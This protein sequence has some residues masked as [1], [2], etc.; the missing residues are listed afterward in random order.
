[1]KVQRPFAPCVEYRRR[2]MALDFGWG[3]FDEPNLCKNGFRF[4]KAVSYTVYLLG[5]N[6][7][8]H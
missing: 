6:K 3:W 7:H 8:P 1:V 5:S 2:C 4:Q